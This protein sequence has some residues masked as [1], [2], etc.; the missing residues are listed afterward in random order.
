MALK[1][2]K[3]GWLLIFLIGLALVG[4]SLYKYDVIKIGKSSLGGSSGGGEKVDASQ[5]LPVN[6]S[7]TSTSDSGTV[8]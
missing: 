7:D 3:G 1:I 6:V 4:Y 2:E 8:G 5:P